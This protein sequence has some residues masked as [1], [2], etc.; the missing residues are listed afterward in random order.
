MMSKNEKEIL[1]KQVISEA[2]T[3]WRKRLYVETCD[4]LGKLDPDVPEDVI[5]KRAFDTLANAMDG[6]LDIKRKALASD[7]E[8]VRKKSSKAQEV[9]V[10]DD[11]D[12]DESDLYEE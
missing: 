7:L 8:E 5:D 9:E 10:P 2:K 11:E 6:S 4:R 12:E 3:G 1:E